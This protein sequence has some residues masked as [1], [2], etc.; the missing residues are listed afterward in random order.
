MTGVDHETTALVDEAARWFAANRETCERPFVPALRRRF[1]I[2]GVDACRAMA[3]ANR[4][5]GANAI[6]T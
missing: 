3:E 4:M 6:A 1:G 2:S 5:G